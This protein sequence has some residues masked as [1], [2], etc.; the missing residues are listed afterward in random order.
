MSDPRHDFRI[1]VNQRGFLRR[2]GATSLC[3]IVDLTARGLQLRAD[4]PLLAGDRVDI[5]CRLESE[6]MIDCALTLTHAA[7]GHAGGHLVYIS[8]EHHR[9]LMEFLDRQSAAARNSQ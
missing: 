4:V 5:E 2:H 1:P 7:G 9:Q 6:R 3:T 8:P